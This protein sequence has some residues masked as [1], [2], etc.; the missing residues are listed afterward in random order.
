MIL[1]RLALLT[2]LRGRPRA[3]PSI[4]AVAGAVCAS[5]FG[6]GWMAVLALVACIVAA[7]TSL[8]ALARRRELA[9]LR[10]LGMP[11]ASLVMMLELE[12]L[13]IT[14]LG[15]LAGVGGS[16]LAAW[17]V[18]RMTGWTRPPPE[19][20]TLALAL[21]GTALLAAL[22]PAIRAGRHDVAAS[23]ALIPPHQ[24]G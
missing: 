17:P 21:L 1:A 18:H 2:V 10:A 13:W 6:A 19:L 14:F 23:L 11:A 16:I 22:V 4:V 20:L 24:E 9:T 3:W 12:A 7:N 5:S 15:T 8:H